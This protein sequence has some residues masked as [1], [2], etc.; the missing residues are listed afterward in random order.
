MK[1]SLESYIADHVQSRLAA[2][3]ML[4]IKFY[5][6]PPYIVDRVVSFWETGTLTVKETKVVEH[7]TKQPWRR[8]DWSVTD[9]MPTMAVAVYLCRFAVTYGD[10][11]LKEA[12]LG[13]LRAHLCTTLPFHAELLK[14]VDDCYSAEDRPW[15]KDKD[16]RKILLS[17]LCRHS[18]DI[19]LGEQAEEIQRLCN[20]HPQLAMDYRKG[21]MYY[22]D[23]V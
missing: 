6:F 5:D 4:E 12:A 10:E 14:A 15:T 7:C 3:T 11:F 13:K 16:M 22:Y 23:Q 20:R 1:G 9:K 21:I 18:C 17:A 2:N 19:E 8:Q